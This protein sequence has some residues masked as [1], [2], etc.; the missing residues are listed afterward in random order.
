MA[1]GAVASADASIAMNTHERQV[2]DN[3]Y[4][5]FP[6]PWRP[7]RIERLTDPG[8]GARFLCQDLGDYTGRRIPEN[9]AIWVAGCGT[10]QALL[11]ALR[12]PQAR[13]LG[14]DASARSLQICAESAADLGVDNLELA[15]EGITQ[16]S[17]TDEF[18]HVICTGVIHHNPDP[19]ACLQRLSQALRPDGVLELMVY[20]AFHRREAVVFQ[21]ALRLLDPERASNDI[22]WA[23]RLAGR[24]GADTALGREFAA[25]EEP[26]DEAWADTWMHPC[27]HT[28]TVDGLWDL[29]VSCGLQVEAPT[30]NQFD[31]VTG[32]WLWHLDLDD[33]ELQ[34]RFDALD[35]RAR[36][37]LVNLLR[38]D[39][40][41]MLW[42]YLTPQGRPRVTERDRNEAFLDTVFT[43]TRTGRQVHVLDES[44]RGYHRTDGVGLFPAGRPSAAVR[45]VHEAADGVRPIRRILADLGEVTPYRVHRARMALTTSRFPYLTAVTGR[46]A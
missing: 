34:E 29:A 21:E 26:S 16:A 12:F 4:R 41:P 19:R 40:S 36:W 23:R 13:V 42:F 38:L 25:W 30:V 10:N 44:G 9:P 45:A 43:R 31:Q 6:Y 28:Y 7:M 33:S 24:A 5:R 35:D 27:E 15:Q 46:A 3:F 17:R 8:F 37:Q 39:R 1:Q 14:T 18:D 32:D 2:L 20:N 22:G 11:T